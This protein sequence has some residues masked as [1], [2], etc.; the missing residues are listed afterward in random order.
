MATVVQLC[1]VKNTY[2]EGTNMSLV[3]SHIPAE[4]LVG[5]MLMNTVL[6]QQEGDHMARCG[7]CHDL[8]VHETVRALAGQNTVVEEPAGVGR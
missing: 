7:T 4:R 1:S 8:M 2:V 6:T 5:V 3:N